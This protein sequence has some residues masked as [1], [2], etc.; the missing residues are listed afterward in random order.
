MNDRTAR[1]RLIIDSGDGVNTVRVLQELKKEARDTE[2]AFEGLTQETAETSRALGEMADDS[3]KGADRLAKLE[4]ASAGADRS[5]ADLAGEAGAVAAAVDRMAD[6]AAEADRRLSQLEEETADVASSM[7]RLVGTSTETARAVDRMAGGVGAA[8]DRLA[9]LGRQAGSAGAGIGPLTPGATALGEAGS[10][11][12]SVFEDGGGLDQFA[13]Y[14]LEAETAAEDL[15]V[16]LDGVSDA[17]SDYASA[18]ADVEAR[19]RDAEEAWESAAKAMGGVEDKAE[20]AAEAVD[21]LGDEADQSGDQ[22]DGLNNRGQQLGITFGQIRNALLAI[23]AGVALK[24]ITEQGV[25]FEA[26]I[27]RVGGLVRGTAE[28]MAAL[29][30]A[31][32]DAAGAFGTATEA[33]EAAEALSLAGLNVTEI[34]EALDETMQL[35]AIEMLDVRDAAEIVGTALNQ[36]QEDA[37]Q[38]GR[39]VDALAAASTESA[40]AVKDMGEALALAGGSARIAGLDIELTTALLGKLADA[41]LKGSQGGTALNRFLQELIVPRADLEEIVGP[42]DLKEQGFEEVFRR[43]SRLLTEEQAFEI[44]DERAARAFAFLRPVADDVFELEKRIRSL[45]GV[46]ADMA[47]TVTDN[48]GGAFREMKAAAQEAFIVFGQSGWLEGLT[49]ALEEMTE[50]MDSVPFQ[51]FAA[52]AG[53]AFGSIADS[54]AG[55]LALLQQLNEWQPPA[56]LE[57]ILRPGTVG[58]GPGEF[59]ATP[60]GDE[61]PFVHRGAGETSAFEALVKLGRAGAEERASLEEQRR[62]MANARQQIIELAG[63]PARAN[64]ALAT[65][66]PSK[67]VALERAMAAYS[68]AAAKAAVA[69][70]SLNDAA[71][72]GGK[73]L[74]QYNAQLEREISQLARLAE[75]ALQGPDAVDSVQREIDQ[76]VALQQLRDKAKKDGKEFDEEDAIRRL[77]HLADLD[78]ERALNE[79]IYEVEKQRRSEREEKVAQGFGDRLELFSESV[80]RAD[81]DS[82]SAERRRQ[83]FDRLRA[84]FEAIVDEWDIESLGII[85]PEQIEAVEDMLDEAWRNAEDAF[86]TGGDEAALRIRGA[87]EGLT[88][89]VLNDLFF[90][91][92]QGI[93]DILERIGQRGANQALFDPLGD[94]LSGRL[95]ELGLSLG[96]AIKDGVDD[97]V[98]PFEKLGSKLDDLFGT[99]GIF[100]DAAGGAA[101]GFAGFKTGSGLADAF[102]GDRGET[103]GKVGGAIGGGIG[104]AAGGPVGAFIGAAAGS[105]LGDIIGGAGNPNSLI[106]GA[107]VGGL[108][109]AIIAALVSKRSNFAGQA[110]I[111]PSTG[112]F[113][114]RASRDQSEEALGNLK[115]AETIAESVGEAIQQF[116]EITSAVLVDDMATAFNEALINIKV[117][118]RDDIEVGNQGASGEIVNRRVFER[119]E[120]GIQE[121]FEYAVKLSLQNLSGDSADAVTARALAGT[122][123]SVEKISDIVSRIS[124]S[125][126]FTEEPT[127]VFLENLHAMVDAF[128]DGAVASGRFAESTRA[129]AEAQLD[130]LEEFAEKFDES[131]GERRRRV[132]DP[133]AQQALDLAESHKLLLREAIELNE[134][135]EKAAQALSGAGASLAGQPAGGFDPAAYLSANP[136]VDAYFAANPNLSKQFTREDFARFHFE[137]FGRAEGRATGSAAATPGAATDDAAASAD[138][139]AAAEARLAEVRAVASAE[140]AAFIEQASSSPDAFR[141]AAEAIRHLEESAAD[142]DFGVLNTA[143]TEAK[144]AL[145]EG[146]DQTLEERTTGLL[147]PLQLRIREIFDQQAEFIETATLVSADDE[148]L[149]QRLTGI[150]D[151]TVLEL[152]KLIEAAGQTPEALQAAVEALQAFAA[153]AESRG[154]DPSLINRQIAQAQEALRTANTEAEADRL[155]RLIS[156]PA[157]EFRSLLERLKGFTE[158]Q[159]IAGSDPLLTSRANSLEIDRFLDALSDD[160]IR[161]LGDVYGQINEAIGQ[162][163]VVMRQLDE[164]YGRFFDNRKDEIDELRQEATRAGRLADSFEEFGK[165]VGRRFGSRL[166]EQEATDLLGELGALLNIAEDETKTVKE[167]LD[168]AEEGR[169][170]AGELL[171]AAVEAFGGLSRTE[172]IVAFVEE[173]ASRFETVSEAIENQRLT[174]VEQLDREYDVLIEIRDKID[175][176]TLGGQL[177]NFIQG[178]LSSGQVTSEPFVGILEQI[179]AISQATAIDR[180]DLADAIRNVAVDAFS[181]EVTIGNT[182]TIDDTAMREV[183]GQILER[184][185]DIEEN[186]RLGST[187]AR[188]GLGGAQAAAA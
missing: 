137:N 11:L 179:V 99:D 28:E 129:I 144:A 125:L 120:E 89:D 52:D 187:E 114:G 135:I 160:E 86:R 178:L 94:F 15:V 113:L 141:A 41:G 116:L 47:D 105:F 126:E 146:L 70:K 175:S 170:V 36:F 177:G 75:A 180:G 32:R 171:D 65:L 72:E 22:I 95:D 162:G 57:L 55:L 149:Q 157:A 83:Q 110:V 106:A 54:V 121:A 168:A 93:G 173:A 43:V 123:A 181:G 12:A 100:A 163:A 148:S 143:L 34:I 109:G 30:E 59:F 7:D 103:G 10:F 64:E 154:A 167:R 81:L 128:E 61:S 6:E 142:L 111:D 101:A 165:D 13:A 131:L 35:A 60:D 118:S 27:D 20:E 124:S 147:R 63:D 39:F 37:D 46:A 5:M 108:P 78:R 127:S 76:E 138:R 67:A 44:F 156:T 159:Q 48:T 155:L 25:N 33:A 133:L 185:N 151:L 107:L 161:Q 74:D 80:G 38:A 115:T 77:A 53:G 140:W 31:T 9:E 14:A 45:Q 90:N 188:V 82:V 96:D 174:L 122:D 79:S 104:F 136:D 3:E 62:V 49:N 68:E 50:L 145:A 17:W 158:R 84:E 19:T 153:E 164:A 88:S 139:A 119:D 42:I 51:Q 23:G 69:Q 132:E 97:F 152:D 183:L 73:V 1:L 4:K 21:R 66:P 26:Q 40:A 91:K 92:G 130:A 117:G 16:G 29:E 172:D 8:D 186:Q 102:N 150:F 166:P 18:F 56:W 87:V 2:G 58:G 169:T 71:E 85:D 134:A 98:A 24:E 112:A 184:L 176:G 182:V